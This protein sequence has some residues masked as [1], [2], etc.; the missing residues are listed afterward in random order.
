MISD[1][2][3]KGFGGGKIMRKMKFLLSILG[4]ISC[5]AI[6]MDI[7]FNRSTVFPPEYCAIFDE[8]GHG[9]TVQKVAINVSIPVRK[10]RDVIR[11]EKNLEQ[12]TGEF[13]H[14]L[15]DFEDPKMEKT[16]R[17]MVIRDRLNTI[18]FLLQ[19]SP[20]PEMLTLLSQLYKLPLDLIQRIAVL[21]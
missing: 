10:P 11:A 3:L 14:S 1:I 20:A 8:Q 2:L 15:C 17:D 5:D 7:D 19:N 13:I 9:H 18:R 21:K 16:V 4:A 6:A 12:A